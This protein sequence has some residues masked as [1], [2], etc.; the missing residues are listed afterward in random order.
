MSFN[1][2]DDNDSFDFD[3]KIKKKE[4]KDSYKA[5]DSNYKDE[6]KKEDNNVSLI[7]LKVAPYNVLKTYENILEDT[8]HHP[9]TKVIIKSI[10]GNGLKELNIKVIYYKKKW[11]A[12][13]SM[14]LEEIEFRRQMS[15]LRKNEERELKN[16][17]KEMIK[18]LSIARIIGFNS[19]EMLLEYYYKKY[20]IKNKQLFNDKNYGIKNFKLDNESYKKYKVNQLELLTK[21]MNSYYFTEV[22][23]SNIAQV[24]D[25]EPQRLLKNESFER[26]TVKNNDKKVSTIKLSKMIDNINFKDTPVLNNPI[27]DHEYLDINMETYNKIKEIKS[28]KNYYNKKLIKSQFKELKIFLLKIKY[29]RNI[30]E[31]SNKDIQNLVDLTSF[32]V[33]SVHYYNK[34]NKSKYVIH[35]DDILEI[36]NKIN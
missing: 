6:L 2:G 25:F 20:K 22:D 29:I 36:L 34:F 19:K 33:N 8:T 31:L 7:S 35:P 4:R 24:V 13:R 32:C 9:E 12:F 30:K 16:I 23:D 3:Y 1:I 26:E 15:E 17:K 21:I 27:K 14:N 28:E 5:A 11:K 18:K 10:I